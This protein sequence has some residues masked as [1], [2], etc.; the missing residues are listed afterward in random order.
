[1]GL[2]HDDRLHEYKVNIYTKNGSKYEGMIYSDISDPALLNREFF[3][4]YVSGDWCSVSDAY[5]GEYGS[6]TVLTSEIEAIKLIF[7]K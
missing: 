5:V 4:K 3:N 6:I 1:M 7:L 2:R